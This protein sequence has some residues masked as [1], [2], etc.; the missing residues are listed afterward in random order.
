MN[1]IVIFGNKIVSKTTI[2]ACQQVTAEG[3]K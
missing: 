2:Y 1:T 3:S